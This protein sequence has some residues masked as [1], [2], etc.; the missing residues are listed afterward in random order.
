MVEVR[1]CCIPGNLI[2][3]L[4][5]TAGTAAGLRLRPLTDGTYAF[6]SEDRSDI[7]TL[8][9]FVRSNRKG[10]GKKTWRKK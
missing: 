7:D 8:P 5:L 10:G 2:G 1:C 6:S 4:P 9:G 3:H